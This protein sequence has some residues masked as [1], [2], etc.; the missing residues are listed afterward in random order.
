MKERYVNLMEKVLLAY[1]YEH[2]EQYLN[3]VRENG[4]TEHGFPRLTADIGI[5]IAHGRCKHLIPIFLQM[6]DVC[7]D[8]LLRPYVK[9]ANEF[10]VREIV[11]CINEVERAKAVEEVHIQ[12]WKQKISMIVPNECY[13]LKVESEEDLITNWAIFGALSE[14]AR[15]YFGLGNNTDFVDRQLSCQFKWLDENGMYKDN[16]REVCHQPILYD[17]VSRGLLSLLLHLG[18]RGKYFEKIDCALKKAGLLTLK[19][20]SPNGEVPFGGRSNQFLHNEA[21]M[22]VIFEY[23]ANRYASLGNTELAGTFKAAI[24]RALDVTEKW[25]DRE[26]I[27]HIKNRFPTETGYGCEKYAYFDKYMITVASILYMACLLCDETAGAGVAPPE[28]QAAV[29]QTGSLFHKVFAHA[30]GWTLEWDTAADSHYDCSG[31][32]RV[33][34]KDAPPPLCLSVPCTVNGNY[35]TEL[36]DAV[37]LAIAPGVKT[38]GGWQYATGTDTRYTVTRLC[39]D[40]QAD[41]AF[42]ALCCTFADGSTVRSEYAVRAKEVAVRLSGEGELALLLPAF[43]FDGEVYPDIVGTPDA[44]S[45]T[46]R[47][48]TCRFTVENG[49]ITDTGR[50]AAN[51]SGHY[52]VFAA[53]GKTGLT[54]RITVEKE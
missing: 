37:P 12:R 30:A 48:W 13:N 35:K 6:M 33:H 15:Y 51:R 29:W 14:Y 49:S 18:Y 3:N 10:S 39:A 2:I 24:K 45:V 11:C 27:R 16:K 36:P 21:W 25:L 40:A 54:V 23:E 20:Q 43:A 34:K 53:E 50:R 8:M 41:T 9:S 19:M 47:G 31:L 38:A 17:L 26:P 42:A 52:R 46:Y 28:E 7:C 4:L 32:G 5:L 44:L 22:I 1:S